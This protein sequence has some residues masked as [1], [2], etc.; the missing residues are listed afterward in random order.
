[1]PHD[2]EPASATLPGVDPDRPRAAAHAAG[3]AGRRAA[4]VALAE[5]IVAAEVDAFLTWPRG[6]DVAPTVAALR[7]RADEV[8]T[9]ELRRLE[10]R[11]AGLT[12]AQ[13]AEVAKSVHRVVQRLLHA[14]TVRV[15]QLRRRA[16]RRGVRRT[17]CGNCSTCPSRSTCRGAPGSRPGGRSS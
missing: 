9:A 3:A 13:R 2:V 16:G 5:D 4:D 8:V 17:C 14:P 15:R 11:A 1:M 6:S 12:D 10:P 7:T